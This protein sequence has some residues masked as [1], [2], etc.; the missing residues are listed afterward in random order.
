MQRSKDFHASVWEC[1]EALEAF[2]RAFQDY[3]MD[4]SREIAF[5]CAL[6]T[7]WEAARKYQ[8]KLEANERAACQPM[9]VVD[10]PVL[11][12]EA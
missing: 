3:Y 8:A 5:Q 7:V 12:V 9:N 4:N 1:Q 10:L 11:E 2:L 6:A